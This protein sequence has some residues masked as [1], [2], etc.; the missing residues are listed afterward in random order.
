VGGGKF[1]CAGWWGVP[2]GGGA[3]YARKEEN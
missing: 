2:D 1:G 3:W